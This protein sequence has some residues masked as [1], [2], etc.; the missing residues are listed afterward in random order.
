MT[1]ILVE[2]YYPA[3]ISKRGAMCFRRG[4]NYT[5]EHYLDRSWC[6]NGQHCP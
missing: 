4:I 3:Y 6:W 1:E 2:Q 5:Y